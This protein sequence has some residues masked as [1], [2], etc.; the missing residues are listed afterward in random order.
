MLSQNEYWELSF[1]SPFEFGGSSPG[2]NIVLYRSVK[3]GTVFGSSLQV[4]LVTVTMRVVC[5][6]R[7][8]IYHDVLACNC[9]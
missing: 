8:V 2:K 3:S 5:N 1:S 6:D 4:A 9:I 7:T